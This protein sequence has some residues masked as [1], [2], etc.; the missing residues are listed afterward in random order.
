MSEILSTL[1]AAFLDT[2]KDSPLSIGKSVI[3]PMPV[4]ASSGGAFGFGRPTPKP[5]G[6]GGPSGSL[7][8]NVIGDASIASVTTGLNAARTA[9]GYSN[10][11]ITYTSTLLNNYTGS[12]LSITNFDTLLIYTNGGITFN[13]AFGSNL[14]NYIAS[15]GTAVFGVFMWGN[16]GAITNFTYTNNPYAYKGTQGNQAATMTKLVSHPIT[17]NISTAV[18]GSSFY[19]PT[20][21]VQSDATSIAAYPDGTSMVAYQTAPR[22][23]GVNLFPP[24]AAV[25]VNRLFLNSVLWAGGLLN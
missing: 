3:H 24:G 4:F 18:T 6:G 22:R 17:S 11:T 16:V 9:Q 5:A 25:N 23:V 2:N 1:S 8:L 10:V 14:N 13:A 20:I 7:R 12:N 21:V 19:T 15:G